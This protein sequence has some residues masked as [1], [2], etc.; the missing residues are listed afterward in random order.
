[1]TF[2]EEYEA[3]LRRLAGVTDDSLPVSVEQDT[4][5]YGG[6]ETC[7]WEET[8]FYVKVRRNDWTW[9]EHARSENY[10]GMADIINAISEVEL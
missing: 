6:C 5:Y 3:R 1:M 4:V 8:V 2:K 7:S 10:T 9:N